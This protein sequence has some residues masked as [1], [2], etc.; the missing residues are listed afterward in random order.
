MQRSILIQV[1]LKTQII[2]KYFH[3]YGCS[4]KIHAAEYIFALNLSCHIGSLFTNEEQKMA[5]LWCSWQ[6]CPTCQPCSWRHKHRLPWQR[7][8][9]YLLQLSNV[10]F[11]LT[12]QTSTKKLGNVSIFC[13]WLGP[14]SCLH[15]SNWHNTTESVTQLLYWNLLLF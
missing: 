10:H 15:H 9:Q 5:G 3:L 13:C 12:K 4:I 7:S 11:F 2:C 14:L 6:L 8:L 1:G